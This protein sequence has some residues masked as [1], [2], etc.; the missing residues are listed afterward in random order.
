MVHF[1]VLPLLIANKEILLAMPWVKENISERHTFLP[2]KVQER[3][4]PFH[5]MSKVT[6]VAREGRTYGNAVL[7][8]RLLVI[9]FFSC[10]D[11]L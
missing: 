11:Q 9:R 1:L 2:D 6:P 8:I 10:L 3:S 5:D 4:H 7:H